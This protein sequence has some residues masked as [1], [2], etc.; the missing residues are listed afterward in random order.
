MPLRCAVPSRPAK[1]VDHRDPA[2]EAPEVPLEAESRQRTPPASPGGKVQGFPGQHGIERSRHEFGG[3]RE[4][5]KTRNKH[6]FQLSLQ[7]KTR[8]YF[9][10]DSKTGCFGHFRKS[11][12]L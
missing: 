11:R 5:G 8:A 3:D 9:L 7:T 2:P 6:F 10:L 1:E 4:N 12:M